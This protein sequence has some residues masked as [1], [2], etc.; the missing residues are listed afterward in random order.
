MVKSNVAWLPFAL[1]MACVAGSEGPRGPGAPTEPEPGLH[2]DL[3]PGP[4]EAPEQVR[5]DSVLEMSVGVRNHGSRSAGYGWVIRVFLSI[6]PQIE[7]SDIQIDQFVAYRELPAGADDQYLRIRKLVRSTP[8]G[9]Y[10][11]GSIVDVTGAV[12][13]TN[14]G[15]NTLFRPS[16]I[17]LMPE[18]PP[19]PEDE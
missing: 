1:S 18:L 9:A 10:Y 14:E 8:T 6:D 2:A 7:A 19:I 15:N 3:A 16:V 11:L 17:L 5:L 4:I 12:P 13:E